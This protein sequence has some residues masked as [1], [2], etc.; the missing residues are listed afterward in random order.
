MARLH[1]DPAI[2][3]LKRRF[4]RQNRDITKVN[5]MQSLKIRTLESETAR[6]LAENLLLREQIIKLETGLSRRHAQEL[7]AHVN[8]VKT[9]LDQKAHELGQV[10]SELG[11]LQTRYGPQQSSRRKSINAGGTGSPSTAAERPWRNGVAPLDPSRNQYEGRLPTILE[12]KLYPRWTWSGDILDLLADGAATDPANTTDS[13]DIGPPPVA[14]FEAEDDPPGKPSRRDNGDEQNHSSVPEPCGVTARIELRKK[15]RESANV[16]EFKKT[17]NRPDSTVD[18]ETGLSPAKGPDES[19]HPS[20]R[21]GAKRKFSNKDEDQAG[22]WND[23]AGK[24]SKASGSATDSSR[25]E[26][27]REISQP[28][29]EVSVKSSRLRPALQPRSTN[30]D[31]SS[32]SK[33]V[34]ATEEVDEV[35]SKPRSLSRNPSLNRKRDYKPPPSSSA[36]TDGTL[37]EQGGESDGTRK[38]K[39]K[40]EDQSE[41]DIRTTKRKEARSE[42]RPQDVKQKEAYPEPETPGGTRH[43]FPRAQSESAMSQAEEARDT[44]IPSAEAGGANADSAMAGGRPSRRPRAVINYAQPNLRDKMRRPTKELVD[45]VTGEGKSQQQKNQLKREDGLSELDERVGSNSRPRSPAIKR[46]EEEEEE[47]DGDH[48]LSSSSPWKDLASAPRSFSTSRPGS[49]SPTEEAGASA[50]RRSSSSGSQI[51]ISALM[52][53]TGIGNR[54]ATAAKDTGKQTTTGSPEDNNNN[55][56]PH[57]SHTF[58]FSGSSSFEGDSQVTPPERASTRLLTRRH[59]TIG[60]AASSITS[61]SGSA[62]SQ[63]LSSENRS[64]PKLGHRRSQTAA[65][66]GRSPTLLS[67]QR[68]PVKED[69]GGSRTVKGHARSAS[70]GRTMGALERAAARRRSMML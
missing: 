49:R 33:Q 16:F 58:E 45:A 17:S 52:A 8:R 13:P 10:I 60:N 51:A 59:S 67:P 32:P 69:N 62:S 22:S 65:L 64:R 24:D 20:F 57:T 5:S 21:T 15:R 53:R 68:E 50:H 39:Q 40:E 36:T 41:E 48:G 42:P 3:V 63:E 28:E 4:I 44:P 14:H 9:R 29:G 26:K 70:T 37:R 55:N 34:N 38:A 7:Y 43:S 12:D 6:L 56:S 35:I 47:E 54:R 2:D 11:F 25:K 61:S 66:D 30:T 31:P 46:E 23:V 27:N 19:T 18:Q 1:E